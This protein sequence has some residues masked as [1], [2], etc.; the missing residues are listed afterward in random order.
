VSER[1]ERKKEKVTVQ[2]RLGLVPEEGDDNNIV[3]IN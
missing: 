1:H 2:C 3:K